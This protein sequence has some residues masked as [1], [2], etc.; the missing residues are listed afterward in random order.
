MIAFINALFSFA[1]TVLYAIF[2]KFF[3]DVVADKIAD[4]V[5]VRMLHRQRKPKKAETFLF[6]NSC[7]NDRIDLGNQ[8]FIVSASFGSY[9]TGLL[10]REHNFVY[11]PSQIDSPQAEGTGGFDPL[12]RI[13]HNL[14]LS[15]GKRIVVIAAGG[16]MGKSTLA[17]K[18]IR[19]LWSRQEIRRVLGDSA[20]EQVVNIKDGGVANTSPGFYDIKT[21]LRKVLKEQLRED[22][23]ARMHNYTAIQRILNAVADRK[24][25]FVVDNLET[26]DPRE[27]SEFVNEIKPLATINS[28]IL[29]TTRTIAPVENLDDVYIVK[30]HPLEEIDAA[31]EFIRWHIQTYVSTINQL[32]KLEEDI[33]NKKKIRK[34][35][36]KTGGIPL[37]MQLVL[38]GIAMSDWGY[39]DN[40]PDNLY[41]DSL[42]DYLYLQ[43][44]NDLVK[45]GD[46]GRN[47]LELLMFIDAELYKGH[48][49]NSKRL[50]GWIRGSTIRT[51]LAL[52]ISMLTD[53]FLLVNNGSQKESDFSIVPSLSIFLKN[54]TIPN[55]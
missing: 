46:D 26:V 14:L 2:V 34:L 18:V 21:F 54:K 44:W 6:D 5:V 8:R 42:L 38:S 50:I 1:G 20:K 3:G 41:S 9:F 12:Q 31:Q 40:I 47:A 22:Y 49:I 35:L 51:P 32:E 36:S 48:K 55:Q 23:D 30:L 37:I 24:V 39:L 43:S 16:G 27:V 19:C 53:R 29:I 52:C 11:V 25:I 45:R 17:A 10:E 7:G 4:I 15:S 13:Y 33:S 28:K